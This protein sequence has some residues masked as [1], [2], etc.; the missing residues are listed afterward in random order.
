MAV[1]TLTQGQQTTVDEQ[2]L[3]LVRKYKWYA[4]KVA[5]G[6]YYATTQ[7]Q[8][9]DGHKRLYLHRLLM[10]PPA[11]LVVDHIDGNP[12]NNSRS[13]L[14]VCTQAQNLSAYRKPY[15]NKAYSKYRGVY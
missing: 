15:K 8:T 11:G 6:S 3:E 5:S 9:E 7:I 12:L 13:N 10:N 4:L 1:I 2:D 14:R